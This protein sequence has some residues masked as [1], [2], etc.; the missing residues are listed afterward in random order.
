[1]L[2]TSA[3]FWSAILDFFEQFDTCYSSFVH[4]PKKFY[5]PESQCVRIYL[6]VNASEYASFKDLNSSAARNFEVFDS[7]IRS[8]FTYC[9]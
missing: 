3:L 9:V 8:D 5:F 6:Q 4:S 2:C 7:E 1:M